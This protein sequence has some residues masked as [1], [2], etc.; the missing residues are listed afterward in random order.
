[1]TKEITNLSYFGI[2]SHYVTIA[3]N[4]EIGLKTAEKY[5]NNP[6]YRIINTSFNTVMFERVP[7]DCDTRSQ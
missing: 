4:S 7:H 2:S 1:M 3:I 6:D 5:H